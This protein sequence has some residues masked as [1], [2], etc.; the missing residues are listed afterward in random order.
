MGLRKRLFKYRYYVL[1]SLMGLS[2]WYYFC[3]PQALFDDP[4][5][6]ILNDNRGEL[7]AARIAN[8]GQWRFPPLEDIPHKYEEALIAFE[9]RYYY[10]H[11]GVNP[12]ATGRAI[13]QNIKAG[14]IVSGGSTI[15]MQ[16]IRLHRKGKSRSVWEKFIEAILATRLE[17]RYSKK[18]ILALYASHAPYGGNTV[19]LETAAWR[20]FGRKAG[21]LSWAETALLAVLPNQPSLL[22]PGKNEALLKAKRDRLLDILFLRGHIDEV[23]LD[24]AKNEPLPQKPLP[25]PNSAP[26]LLSKAIKDGLSGQVITSTI[27]PVTQLAA[28]EVMKRHQVVLKANEVHNAAAIIVEIETG[29]VKAY[30]GNVFDQSGEHGHQVDV[31]QSPRSTG[32]LLKPFLYALM[33]DE[34]LMLPN[35]LLPD[36]PIFFEGFSP[37]NY[38][39]TYD[40]AVHAKTALSRSLNIPAVH[41]LM[42]YGY[43]KFHH[44]LN[45]MGMS[46]LTKPPGHY[47]LSMILGG[48]E[49]TLWDMTAMYAGMARTLVNYHGNPPDARYDQNAFDQPVY[50]NSTVHAQKSQDNKQ[51]KERGISEIKKQEV[52]AGSIL[53]AASIWFTFEAMKEVYRPDE[54]ASWK[55]FSSTEEIAWKTGTSF[56]HRDGWAIGVSPRYVVGVWVGNADGEGRPG[57]TGIKAAAPIMLDLFELVASKEWFMPPMQE[58]TIAA[59]DRQSG[60]LASPYSIQIDTTL[61]P[62]VGLRTSTS[63]FHRKLHLDSTGNYR[64]HG[65]CESVNRMKHQN[66]FVLPPQQAFHF[67]RK[68]PTYQELPPL[69]SDCY[70]SGSN[71]KLMDM[72]YPK[73]QA[74][75]YIP[76]DLD[77]KK[78][79]IIFEVAHRNQESQ[80][81]WHLDDVYVGSTLRDHTLS[82]LPSP[83]SHTL[84]VLDEDGNSL[85]NSF[86]VLEKGID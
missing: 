3:L 41:M 56:G 26:H 1:V 58:L 77:G 6:T 75:V 79:G 34:G 52:D 2:V 85:K 5:A 62:K 65:D 38:S 8:D 53:S 27:D 21:Q 11:F 47:G 7:I 43:P 39:R 40:G 61:I 20:Y 55:L 83:G 82:L 66:W 70:Q 16:V 46:T 74:E 45:K 71:L 80:L 31:I 42:Q 54:D 29:A 48:A 81:H 69:R 24:L 78:S 76:I 28:G 49:G 9:D 64:V 22:F 12:L 68:N 30:L 33:L 86:K 17:F 73:P 35:T 25:L 36:V 44:K 18:E 51:N 50:V 60:Y 23:G 13:V 72:I 15:S 32:S 4:Y 37:E 19:G 59:V 14:K 67:K 84:T 63:P 57:L 10:K